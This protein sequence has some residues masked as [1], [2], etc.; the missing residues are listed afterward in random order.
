MSSSY[1]DFSRPPPENN[2]HGSL[3]VL[4]S[5]KGDRAED[6]RIRSLLNDY[7]Y[8]DPDDS[9]SSCREDAYDSDSPSHSRSFISSR[10][11]SPR[12]SFSSFPDQSV[13]DAEPKPRTSLSPATRERVLEPVLVAKAHL[14]ALQQ[15]ELTKEKLSPALAALNAAEKKVKN[16]FQKDYRRKLPKKVRQEFSVL[17][18]TAAGRQ[19]G[20]KMLGHTMTGEKLFETAVEQCRLDDLHYEVNAPTACVPPHIERLGRDLHGELE[21]KAFSRW[22]QEAGPLAEEVRADSCHS[23]FQDLFSEKCVPHEKD[24]ESRN[25]DGL[26]LSADLRLFDF[27]AEPEDPLITLVLVLH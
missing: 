24:A 22:K 20:V 6:K 3:R 15:H 12:R 16:D 13:A 19:V 4:R 1:Y 27:R 23:H 14:D 9:S 18:D 25:A 11:P 2:G 5:R 26:H 8:S 7:P 10:S 21:S 17:K